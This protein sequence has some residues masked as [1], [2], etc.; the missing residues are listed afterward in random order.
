MV[1][2]S[3]S[4]LQGLSN[5]PVIRFGM[6]TDPHYAEADP[7][8]SSN[9]YYRHSLDKLE[10]AI[11]KFNQE[12]LDFVIE[13]GDFKDQDPEPDKE[14]TIKYLKAIEKVFAGFNGPRYH[15]L[16]NHD[17]DSISKKE[18]LE[19]IENTGIPK[20]R[21]YYSFDVQGFHFVVL[22]SNYT[23]IGTHY[24]NGN[25]DWTDSN[26]HARQLKWLKKDLANTNKP[27][28]VFVHHRL[29]TPHALHKI[30]CIHNAEKVR[31]ILEKSGKVIAVFQGHDHD[32]DYSSIN[33]IH[34][35]TQF[36]MVVGPYPENNSYAI[37]EVFSDGMI[38]INGFVN[39]EDKEMGK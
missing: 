23:R 28:I 9:R 29:D 38:R 36:A 11:S 12:K 16:G 3:I 15:V 35:Y 8:N 32:G 37:V 22:D 5:S 17:M 34:Y 10:I 13:V 31:R 19:N 18:F 1:G 27:V 14:N 24:N 2:S 39:C 21:T 25:F 20:D 30:Y 4:G 7:P 6:I 33:G 26:I